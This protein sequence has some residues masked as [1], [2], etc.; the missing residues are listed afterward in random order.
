MNDNTREQLEY[1]KKVLDD[2][3]RLKKMERVPSISNFALW[4]VLDYGVKLSA[5][6]RDWDL[7]EKVYRHF[8]STYQFDCSGML[9]AF[10]CNPPKMLD[11][12]GQGYNIFDD[13]E[14]TVSLRDF[15]LLHEDE[16]DELMADL[17]A[18]IWNTLLPRK[19]ERWGQVTVGDFKT[20]I[21][22]FALFG[23]FLERM[24]KICVEEY[25]LPS[26]A[27]N[28]LN[29][30][31]I[32]VLYNNFRGIKGTSR[33]LRRI[34]D[35]VLQVV[36]HFNS[37]D[38]IIT[39]MFLSEP[40]TDTFAFGTNI[41]MLAHNFLSLDQWD[42]FYWPY[43][44]RIID[45][46]VAADATVFIFAEGVISRFYDYFK[47]VPAGHVAIQIEQD[48]VF[49]FKA[50]L[51]NICVV[52]GMSTKLL[53]EGSVKQCVDYAKFLCDELG[54]EGG[55][56]LSQDKMMSYLRDAKPENVKAVCDFV[57]NYRL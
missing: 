48:D 23:A 19:F 25:G 4:P 50:N 27:G 31:G 29:M 33:D 34:P 17:P 49:D 41:G 28:M 20:A 57:V 38:D 3:I 30:A 44:K 54:K 32:E 35:K 1:R 18:L 21:D 37:Q 16:Y 42:K 5:A 39:N 6:C 36:Q 56:M 51:P 43:L 46:A 8:L 11:N 15:D 24:S 10:F 47:D 26:M 53:G 45:S 40:L 13:I 22:E 2:S 7:M 55:F 14:D 52:G 12:I 9:G